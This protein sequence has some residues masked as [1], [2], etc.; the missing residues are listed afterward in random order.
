MTNSRLNRM[1]RLRE[2]PEFV[3]LRR[4]QI[5]ELI[6]TGEFPKPIPLSDTGRAVAW[7]EGD[8]IAWQNGR[9]A[10]RNNESA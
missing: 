10:A 8:L 2:L 1:F 5:G 3:G 9:I 7:L 6:K 4:T